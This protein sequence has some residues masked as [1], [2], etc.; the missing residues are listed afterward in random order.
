[1]HRPSKL[2]QR[3]K[4]SFHKA[5]PSGILEISQKEIIYKIMK[6]EFGVTM[7]CKQNFHSYCKT[8]Y[9]SPRDSNDID[10]KDVCLCGCHSG[11]EMKDNSFTDATEKF[12]HQ[13]K[14]SLDYMIHHRK[15]LEK[16]VENTNKPKDDSTT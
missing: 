16:Q 10:S 1:M 12:I 8:A 15:E 7:F 6:K 4:A 9:R 13:G 14:E 11:E 3:L 5:T 2:G